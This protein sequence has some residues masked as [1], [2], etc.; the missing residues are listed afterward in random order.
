MRINRINYTSRF[1]RAMKDLDPAL[2]KIVAERDALFRQDCFAPRL[3]AHKLHG[4]L[5]KYWSFSITH[6]HRV[7]FQFM[8]GN[9]VVFIDVGNHSIYR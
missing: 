9:A 5:K 4:K 7:L 3:N 6:S 8:K 1:A 2:R